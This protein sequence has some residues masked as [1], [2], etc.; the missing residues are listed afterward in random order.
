M[1]KVS[2][3]IAFAAAVIAAILGVAAS[4]FGQGWFP[5]GRRNDDTRGGR[6][7]LR[8]VDRRQYL[9]GA[10]GAMVTRLSRVKE[11]FADGT[12]DLP[13]LVMEPEDLV[14]AN[15]APGSSA[16]RRRLQHQVLR[17]RRRHREIDPSEPV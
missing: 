11:L 5:L 4:N 8:P 17:L 14:Q 10:Y 7:R 9:A 13:A 1:K 12:G 15:T 6:H 3:D 2:G 16:R